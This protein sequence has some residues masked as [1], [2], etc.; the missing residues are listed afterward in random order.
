MLGLKHSLPTPCAP[1][2]AVSFA[3]VATEDGDGAVVTLMDVNALRRAGDYSQSIVAN[4]RT[5]LVVLDSKLR[6]KTASRAF[7]Q[8]FRVTPAETEG[9]H[10]YKLGN[11]QWDIAALRTLLE[12]V[13]PKDNAVE[14]YEVR[15]TFEQL[16]PRVMQ[17]A[18]SR[19]AFTGPEALSAAAEFLPEAVL[20]DLGLPGMDGFEVARQIRA[21]G[22]FAHR[23]D[24][25]CE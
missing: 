7:Y 6:V 25:L 4:V 5:P 14:D 21:R 2:S 13:L 18:A 20:L 24:W 23:H 9:R 15:H 10:F 17:L 1:P 12:E 19:F 22:R 16:G 8:H 3:T 11:R